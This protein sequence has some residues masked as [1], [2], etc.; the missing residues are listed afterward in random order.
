MWRKNNQEDSWVLHLRL[1]SPCSSFGRSRAAGVLLYQGA[2]TPSLSLSCLCV[3]IPFVIVVPMALSCDL[4]SICCPCSI[5]HLLTDWPAAGLTCLHFSTAFKVLWCP[6]LFKWYFW[7][8]WHGNE[9]AV[10]IS[11]VG[12]CSCQGCLK[13]LS[14]FLLSDFKLMEWQSIWKIKW[15]GR[16]SVIVCEIHDVIYLVFL[17]NKFMWPSASQTGLKAC[18]F[19]WAKVLWLSKLTEGWSSAT[20]VCSC[21]TRENCCW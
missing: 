10:E 3:P 2:A 6:L 19:P 13:R 8:R 14:F 1:V 15:W 16:C 21:W 12:N 4:P 7:T 18:S 5:W 9:H 11:G 20:S 17:Q